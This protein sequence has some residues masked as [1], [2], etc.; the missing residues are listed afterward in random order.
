MHVC[1]TFVSSNARKKDKML[2][3]HSLGNDIKVVVSGIVEH[4]DMCV[5]SRREGEWTGGGRENAINCTVGMYCNV[6]RETWY[7]WICLIAV[8]REE[9][10][11]V[12]RCMYSGLCY[13]FC[14]GMM[15]DYELLSFID[16]GRNEGRKDCRS[17]RMI[18]GCSR[19]SFFTIK[20]SCGTP[21]VYT[22]SG[23][24]DR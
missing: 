1:C 4:L 18:D 13:S 21:T 12:D 20:V 23:S 15:I 24:N 10:D 11:P 17:L 16:E 14:S 3:W 8:V 6:V 22:K 7:V 19:L 2:V 5:D 9:N